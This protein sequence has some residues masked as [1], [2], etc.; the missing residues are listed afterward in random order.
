MPPCLAHCP[1]TVEMNDAPVNACAGCNLVGKHV[2]EGRE[3]SPWHVVGM[4]STQELEYLL[5]ASILSSKHH[6]RACRPPA[7]MASFHAPRK[8]SCGKSCQKCGLR[9]FAGR[10]SVVRTPTNTLVPELQPLATVLHCLCR[11]KQ[12]KAKK[13]LMAIKPLL[14]MAICLA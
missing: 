14:A 5:G 12:A 4:L 8:L 11:A 6:Q 2:L 13:A 7:L 3:D 10:K 9:V 1:V